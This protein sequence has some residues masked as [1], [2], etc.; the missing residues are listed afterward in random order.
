MAVTESRAY[1]DAS[2]AESVARHFNS[3]ALAQAACLTYSGQRSEGYEVELRVLRRVVRIA[4]YLRLGR[5][6]GGEGWS[7]G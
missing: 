4:W 6:E 2:I 3:A 5:E 1:H 7:A